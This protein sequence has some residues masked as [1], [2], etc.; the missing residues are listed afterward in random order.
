MPLTEEA[1]QKTAFI[2]SLGL[3]MYKRVP[4]GYRNAPQVFMRLIDE[5]ITRA[6]L[7]HCVKAFVDDITAH[8][9]T[10]DAYLQAQRAILQALAD[11]NWLVT[12]EKMYLG[13]QSIEL[14]GHLV[15]QGKIKPVPGKMEAIDKLI[16]PSNVRQ[17]KS[18]LGLVGFYRRFVRKFASISSPLVRLL[19]KGVDYK[20]TP[21]QQQAF[22]D[23]KEALK[24]SSGL[25]L[26][27]PDG[28]YRI[29]TDYSAEGISAIL[30]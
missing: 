27:S 8:G 23:L 6:K 20:W 28:Y 4:F 10:W 3:Y 25:F 22:Q 5:I 2:S 12:V 17:L 21:I 11:A 24:A 16:P 9:G 30:H 13:Y 29:Y 15:E 26:P 18:F 14:L 1:A 19:A 7:R